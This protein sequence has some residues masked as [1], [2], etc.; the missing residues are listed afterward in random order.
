M[1]TVKESP[2]LRNITTAVS[3]VSTAYFRTL[4]ISYAVNKCISIYTSQIY[5]CINNVT[6]PRLGRQRARST[7]EEFLPASTPAGHYRAALLG[8]PATAP[9]GVRPRSWSTTGPINIGGVL[10]GEE[11]LPGITEQGC[12]GHPPGLRRRVPSVLVGNGPDQHWRSL[13]RRARLPGITERRARGAGHRPRRTSGLQQARPAHLPLPSYS[14]GR[15]STEHSLYRGERLRQEAEH[16]ESLSFGTIVSETWKVPFVVK[17]ANER[18]GWGS[19]R[20]PGPAAKTASRPLSIPAGR[21]RLD[22]EG[23]VTPALLF[24]TSGSL[25][26]GRDRRWLAGGTETAVL[27]SAQRRPWTAGRPLEVRRLSIVLSCLDGPGTLPPRSKSA[28]AGDTNRPPTADS[29]AGAEPVGTAGEGKVTGPSRL[30]SP[31][32]CSPHTHGHCRSIPDST[33]TGRNPSGSYYRRTIANTWPILNVLRHACNTVRVGTV[34]SGPMCRYFVCQ[35]GHM[36]LPDTA[37]SFS[38]ALTARELYH[39]DRSRL[40]PETQTARPRLTARPVQSPLAPPEREKSPDHPD[41]SLRGR[42]PRTPTV[43]ADPSRTRQ[44][45]AETRQAPRKAELVKKRP[46]S[47]AL[48]HQRHQPTLEES[49]PAS[50]P[51]GHY[52]AALLGVPATAP[53]GESPRSRSATGP[54]KVGGVLSGESACR[55][56][57]SD[58]AL[59]AGHCPRRRVS[60]V[61]IG[62]GPDQHWRH[63]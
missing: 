57:P 26:S 58:L 51:A 6:F 3:T 45:P 55:A 8:A 46:L 33:A 49:L 12:S 39:R 41:F 59:R 20:E 9:A 32:A 37:A 48:G 44:P 19:L 63:T 5:T 11:R 21:T 29:S 52:R 14:I 42:V 35:C 56:L 34:H 1:T 23:T 13:N 16:I 15:H 30:F 24:K 17:G 40:E 7:L 4:A 28:G 27:P 54:I 10:A 2:T 25:A 53:A 47:Q 50:P 61:L 18:K 36:D 60:A 31:W 38:R 22:A 43:T 62:N